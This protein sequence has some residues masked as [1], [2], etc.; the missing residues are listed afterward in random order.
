M[1]RMQEEPP[2]EASGLRGR[3]RAKTHA[4]IQ[5]EAM[6][7]FLERGFDATTMDEI[8][9]AA[10]VSRR[11]LFDY[12]ESK[13]EIVFS[14]RADFPNLIAEAIG[15]RPVDEPLLDMVENALVAMGKGYVS[16]QTRDLARLIH[17]TPALKAHDQTK[18]GQ[19]ELA[20]AQ[21]L[22]HRKGLT[23]SDTACRVAAAT[24][25]GIMKLALD[26]WLA[27]KDDSPEKHFKTAFKAL[28]RIAG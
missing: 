27:G 25:I 5:A 13:E 16:P 17:G 3:K 8:A 2:F 10:E 22:A 14:T 20:L 23:A 12:F 1:Q 26:A 15:R 9:A 11:S 24:A 4:R 18:Y 19:I 21:A 6:R 7:L 28:R